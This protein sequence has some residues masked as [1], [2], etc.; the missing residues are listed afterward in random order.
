MLFSDEVRPAY[1]PNEL[2]TT[3]RE[4]VRLHTNLT[5]ETTRYR[6]EIHALLVVLFPEFTQLFADPARQTALALLKRYP[7]ARAI[8]AAGVEQLTSFFQEL[9]PHRYGQRFA[10]RLVEVASNSA[11]S[12]VA[13]PVRARSLTILC[14]QLSHTLENLTQL[15]QEIATLVA[16]DKAVTEL[17]R[18]EE[19]GFCGSSEHPGGAR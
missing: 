7:S 3:Y 18:V 13:H 16:S 1:V 11:A 15:E 10:Q 2:I 12:G 19:F 6:N 9:A 8:T 5:D 17:S 14:D 4:L